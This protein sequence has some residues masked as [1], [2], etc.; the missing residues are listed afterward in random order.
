MPEEP[1]SRDSIEPTVVLADPDR[2]P[3]SLE[4]SLSGGGLRATAYDLGALLFLVH[5][6]LNANVRNIAS[7][8]GGSITNAFVAAHCDFNAVDIAKFRVVTGRLLHRIARQGLWQSGIVWLYIATCAGLTACAVTVW[9]SVCGWLT[10]PVDDHVPLPLALALSLIVLWL[11]SMRAWPIAKWLES[12]LRD[13]GAPVPSIGGL[14]GLTVDH[15]F[16]ATDL[17]F[18]LPYFFSS[19]EGG[20]QFSPVFG[21]A[22]AA[23][24]PL[25]TA[26]RASAAFPPLIPPVRYLP[27]ETWVHLDISGWNYRTNT[28]PQ[29]VWLSDGGIFNNFGTEWHEV[30]QEV[31]IIECAYFLNLAK[32]RD[33]AAPEPDMTAHMARYGEVQLAIDA[34]QIAQ[35][36]Q[37]HSLRVPLVGF[38]V[39]VVRTL[40]VLY[41]STLSGRSKDA[42]RVAVLQMQ[43]FP[44]KWLPATPKAQEVFR[45]RKSPRVFDPKARVETGYEDGALRLYVPYSRPLEDFASLMM[46]FDPF[47]EHAGARLADRGERARVLQSYPADLRPSSRQVGTSFSR[48]GDRQTLMLVIAGYLK[49]RETV[50]CALH[51]RPP[52]MPDAAWFETLLA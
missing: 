10:R 25:T 17:K 40:N 42:E 24:V 12:L 30:R 41:G 48:L 37:Y 52:P 14:A 7:V 4:V 46:G 32:L 16:C 23:S 11:A 33:P 44:D 15:V 20:R 43:A 35:G 2:F 51:Y 45:R 49:T 9:L 47:A 18:G 36:K 28:L 27:C 6:D 50:A 8:S 19:A 38:F 39:N 34:S 29:H 3:Y 22:S 31:W 5:A 21:R 26:T 13:G 1:S